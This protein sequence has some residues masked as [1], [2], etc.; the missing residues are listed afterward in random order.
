METLTEEPAKY[1]V[2]RR[3]NKTNSE[4]QAEYRKRMKAEGWV[5]RPVWLSPESLHIL[6][7]LPPDQTIQDFINDAIQGMGAVTMEKEDV[8]V[9][10]EEW[11]RRLRLARER[12]RRIKEEARQKRENEDGTSKT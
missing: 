1:T 9:S 12:Y 5:Q 2:N 3:T 4:R 11:I 8:G 6:D 7:D 10:R